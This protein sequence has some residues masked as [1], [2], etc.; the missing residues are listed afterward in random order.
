MTVRSYFNQTTITI[1][2]QDE[3]SLIRQSSHHASSLLLHLSPSIQPGTTTST[4][5][6]I[7]SQYVE[8]LGLTSAPLN[9]GGI[10]MTVANS[11]SQLCIYAHNLAHLIV[12]TFTLYVYGWSIF[13]SSNSIPR[14]NGVYVGVPFCGFPKSICTSVNDVVCHGIPSRDEALVSGDIINVDVTVIT[15]EGWHGD[16]SKV[17]MVGK[18]WDYLE[19]V[20]L[21]DEGWDDGLTERER[22]RV[23]LS[24][25]TRESMYYGIHA[26]GEGR[27]I[28]DIGRAIQGHVE[29]YGYA[30][31]R[32]YSGHG[33]QGLPPLLELGDDLLLREGMV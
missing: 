21:D 13:S 30:V 16:T 29:G 3:I 22:D 23:R 33:S 19:V 20:D 18:A 9:Y 26:C 15:G 25:V 24:V 32:E 31:V 7:S 14:G 6:D 27:Q 11:G 28:G 1:K 8:E 4:L 5:D 12:T 17:W 2:T 10:G